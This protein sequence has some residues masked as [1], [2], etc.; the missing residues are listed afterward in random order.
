V[1]YENA[2]SRQVIF[3]GG[4][5][6]D[7]NGTV[8]QGNQTVTVQAPLGVLPYFERVSNV[9]GPTSSPPNMQISL[10]PRIELCLLMVLF[11]Y[12]LVV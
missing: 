10:V 5:W 11:S 2:T 9:S 4:I 1:V 7:Q 12:F 8:I 3:P 6:K